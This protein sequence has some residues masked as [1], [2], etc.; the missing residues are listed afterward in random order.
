M[1]VNWSEEVEVAKKRRR[2]RWLGQ[3]P[4][5]SPRDFNFIRELLLYCIDW[6]MS[7][8]NSPCSLPPE[9]VFSI[10]I[11]SDLFRLSGASISSDG[12]SLS[13]AV[14]PHSCH[15]LMFIT[16]TPNSYSHSLNS[17]IILFAFLR[18]TIACQQ[19]LQ[20]SYSLYRPRS[21]YVQ[22]YRAPSAGYISA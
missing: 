12:W 2:S 9:K 21:H 19:C 18:R 1:K 10:Q 3:P 11:G 5:I 16:L 8:S 15:P 14:H 20:L 22:G 7:G 6:I 17:S 4:P 13:P